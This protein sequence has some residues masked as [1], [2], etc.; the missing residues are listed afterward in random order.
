MFNCF[1][2]LTD[3]KRDQLEPNSR[4]SEQK[5]VPIRR[6]PTTT[7]TR[8]EALMAQPRRV[9]H[10]RVLKQADFQPYNDNGG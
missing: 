2:L 1:D 10:D 6:I 9:V 4:R 3:R 8:M 7:A 5:V